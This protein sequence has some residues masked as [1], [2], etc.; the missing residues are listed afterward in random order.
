MLKCD[1][2][3]KRLQK[4]ID[5]SPLDVTHTAIGSTYQTMQSGSGIN[6]FADP[7]IDPLL[8]AQQSKFSSSSPLDFNR[9]TEQ[10]IDV[11]A[12]MEYNRGQLDALI[13]DIDADE[14]EDMGDEV[15]SPSP[16]A[17]ARDGSCCAGSM[18]PR[19]VAH[20]AADSS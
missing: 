9:D 14:D 18:M 15:S 13:D 7:T 5:C 17:V 20:M 6:S 8:A 19:P 16:A 3:C 4:R 12:T 11:N 2:A 1:E 10:A